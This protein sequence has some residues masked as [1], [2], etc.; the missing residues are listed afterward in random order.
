MS[1]CARILLHK[2][3]SSPA[4]ILDELRLD[5]LL[6]LCDNHCSQ[7]SPQYIS[8][9]LACYPFF[10]TGVHKILNKNIGLDTIMYTQKLNK[11]YKSVN[12]IMKL[13]N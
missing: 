5:D 7:L 4:D 2:E 10:A 1:L 3:T 6:S 13:L 12:N 9:Q 8:N 11:T